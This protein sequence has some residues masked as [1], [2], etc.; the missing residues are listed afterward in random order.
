MSAVQGFYGFAVEYSR[1]IYLAAA[2]YIVIRLALA[3]F[4]KRTSNP[5]RGRLINTVTGEAVPLF[6]S[7]ASIGRGKTCDI[8]LNFNT[9][10]RSHA[11]IAYRNKGFEIYD[12]HSKSGVAVN[13]EK[14]KGRTL[15]R[16]GDTVELGG[17]VYE[18]EELTYKFIKDRSRAAARPSYTVILIILTVIN[19][20]SLYL[21]SFS[22][23]EFNY[24]TALSYVLFI[25][26]IWGYTVFASFA[27]RIHNFELEMLAFLFSSIGLAVTG[28]IYPDGAFRQFGAIFIGAVGFCA[29]VAVMRFIPAVKVL[30]W[31][32]A[33]AAIGLLGATLLLA[34]D[35]N[36]ALNWVTIAG[37]SLQPSELVKVIF[38]FVSAVTLER[39]QS[40]R[41]LTAY[42]IFTAAC[43]GELFVM[44]DFGAALIFFFTFVIAAFMRSGDVK[45]IMLVCFA[46]AL[47]AAVIIFFKPY[48]ATRFATYMHIWEVPDE[49][50]YQ[51]TRTLIYSASGGLFG[52]GL[53][54]GELRYIFAAAEDLIF[55]VVSEEFGL[56][57][58]FLIVAAYILV[59][60]NAVF[61]CRKAKS[62]FYSVGAVLA[63]GMMLFQTALNVLGVTDILPMTGVTLPFVSKG[64]SSVICCFCLFAFIKAA[65]VRTYASF[66]PVLPEPEEEASE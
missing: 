49:G 19:L 10:S 54:N 18:L 32:G 15:L 50:G 45:T 37:I 34:E 12:T 36:G 48:V 51:Q 27:L 8:V 43:V 1:Y 4:F 14:I 24:I 56:I 57:M 62:A 21:N 13:G 5:V 9:V 63:A 35:N 6:D 11:V 26:L 59:T 3:M 55:G 53:G 40:V 42:I 2:L 60:L 39:L 23:G 38:V 30:R 20:I 58:S 61:D 47:G 44:R 31:I 65:D 66:K 16:D 17:L 22:G 41:S 29:L 7:E 28:S 64:G 33:F 25:L 52:L 46:A